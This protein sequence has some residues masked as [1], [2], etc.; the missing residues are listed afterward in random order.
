MNSN[1]PVLLVPTYFGFIESTYDALVLFEAC[2][3]GLIAHVP[4]RPHDRER[5]HVIKSGNIFLYEEST[6]GIKRWTDGIS[7]SPSRI[8]GNFLIYRQLQKPFGP[9]EKKK[10]LKKPKSTNGISKAGHQ[11]NNRSK[12]NLMQMYNHG[13]GSLGVYGEAGKMNPDVER[14]LIGSLVDSYDF[15]DDGLVKKTISVIVN[16]ITHHLVS[17][18]TLADAAARKF[19]IPTKDPK[20]QGLVPR[21]HLLNKQA[22][23]GP[24]DEVDPLDRVVYGRNRYDMGHSGILSQPISYLPAQQQDSS[25]GYSHHRSV[26]YSNGFA[27]PVASSAY[28]HSAPMYSAAPVYGTQYAPTSGI[29]PTAPQSFPHNDGYNSHRYSIVSTAD[30]DGNRPHMPMDGRAS[31]YHQNS[32]DSGLSIASEPTATPDHNSGDY[33]SR[34][35][36][37][38]SHQHSTST[39]GVHNPPTARSLPSLSMQNNEIYRAVVTSPYEQKAM[40]PTHYELGLDNKTAMWHLGGPAAIGHAHYQQAWSATAG[41]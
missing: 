14:A 17:Y 34:S 4:R 6:S 31:L 10:A 11:N 3:S 28:E 24:V 37:N 41:H 30:S 39:G 40:I 38:S 27:I 36:E 35:R 15:M 18:Y 7:W 12:S 8:L 23:R 13:A 1:P 25:L 20:F 21:P 33:Y 26:S 22:F 29:Y 32:Q 2:L 19:N 5:E 16:G 9:G